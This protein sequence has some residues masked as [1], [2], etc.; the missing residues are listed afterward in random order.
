M[1]QFEDIT[2]LECNRKSSIQNDTNDTD[3]SLFTNR[4]GDVVQLEVGDTVELKSAF[5]NKRGC[6]NP[7][8]LEFK[9]TSIGAKSKYLQTE[10]INEL[11]MDFNLTAKLQTNPNNPFDD[12]NSPVNTNATMS[13]LAFRQITNTEIE[14]DLRDNVLNLETNFYKNT[15]GEGYFHLPRRHIRDTT[16]PGPAV[17]PFFPNAESVWNRPDMDLDTPIKSGMAYSVKYLQTKGLHS[18]TTRYDPDYSEAYGGQEGIMTYDYTFN[19][20]DYHNVVDNIGADGDDKLPAVILV[21]TKTGINPVAPTTEELNLINAGYR[22]IGPNLK[23]IKQKNDNSRYTMFE[24][25][26]DWLRWPE[27]PV[28]NPVTGNTPPKEPNYL[29]G[30]TYIN[31]ENWWRWPEQQGAGPLQNVPSRFKRPWFRSPAMFPYLKRSKIISVEVEKGFSSPQSVAEQLTQQFQQQDTDSPYVYKDIE[32]SAVNPGGY[33]PGD[34][35]NPF[36]LA[37]KTK[38]YEAVVCSNILDNTPANYEAYY[39]K[40]EYDGLDGHQ[41]SLEWFRGYH[42]IGMKR[43]DLYEKGTKI[44]NCYGRIPIPAKQEK[45]MD[46]WIPES[47]QDILY[48]SFTKPNYI[49]ND[50]PMDATFLNNVTNSIT[51][52]WLYNT[53]NLEKL[54]DLFDTQSKY[55]ELF[56]DKANSFPDNKV[57]MNR[58]ENGVGDTAWGEN[59]TVDNSRFLHINRFDESNTKARDDY[60]G[61]NNFNILGDDG[62]E[63]FTYETSGKTFSADHRTVPFFFKYDKTY[64]NRDTGGYDPLRLSYGFATKEKLA[65]GYYYIV[66]H[67]ELVN[68]LRPD[69][70]R[71]RGGMD[72]FL[73]PANAGAGPGPPNPYKMSVWNAKEITANTCMIGWDH[74]FTSWGNLTLTQFT[75]QLQTSYDKSFTYGQDTSNGYIPDIT[76]D[77]DGISKANREMS[78]TY[79]GANNVACV[80]DGVSGKFGFEYLHMPEYVGNDF[81]SGS[82]DFIDAKAPTT[83][84][85]KPIIADAGEEVYKIN[86]RL[87]RWSFCPDMA[88]YVNNSGKLT[89][90]NLNTGKIRLDPT[91]LNLSPWVIYDSQMGVTFNF[92]KSAQVDIRKYNVSQEVLWNNST[93]GIMGFSYNQFN[94]KI[95]NATN[96]QQARLRYDNIRNVYNPTTN[97]QIVNTDSNQ[98]NI[99]PYGAIQY[100]TQLPSGLVF[101]ITDASYWGGTLDWGYLPAITQQTSSIKIEGVNPPKEVL[102]P[103]LTIRSDLLSHTKY[104]GGA[105]SG[106]QMPIVAVVNRINAEKDFIQLEGSDVFTVT[107]PIKF[108]SITTAI[109]DPDGSL[110]LVDDGSAVI[111]KITKL[112]S[113]SK[114]DIREEWIEGLKKKK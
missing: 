109:C 32:P 58:Y 40:T 106:L 18:G 62:Y 87:K 51:T 35:V 72:E 107:N 112:D 96:N 108:S 61:T 91:N 21:N 103:Y 42:N 113:L 16:S 102:T 44:N 12:A 94:P 48:G 37:F 31:A 89:S 70:F 7:Q 81:D 95:I 39:S 6:A 36:S 84:E 57:Y 47:N 19:R 69:I 114:Y 46:P 88:P 80:Y 27:L 34:D 25:E 17:N 60:D 49:Q 101:P 68:G 30:S 9:G 56:F 53:E 3:Y 29:D 78:E 79:L 26:Y 86:K 52:G 93:L 110:A 85:S 5:V 59:A 54:Q 66:L 104:I 90:D 77:A 92:G 43:P 22:K 63:A 41:K 55:P 45:G 71:L 64:H 100:T 50:I 67:P 2:L 13:G 8:S 1:S 73:N 11:V 99:N 33:K 15:N 82:T 74:H 24:R 98:F 10:I 97:S 75:G 65:D 4:M 105:T 83:G 111:Y 38:T 20:N 14:R 23:R 76:A 28:V